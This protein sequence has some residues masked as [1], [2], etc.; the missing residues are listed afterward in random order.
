MVLNSRQGPVTLIYMPDTQV[1]D[2]EMLG[3]DRVEA[4]RLQAEGQYRAREEAL[5]RDLEATEATLAEMQA[6]R[7]EGDLT[8]LDA[9]QQAELQ[10][11]IDQR[12][13]IRT[14]LRQVR[15]DLD[16]EIDALGTRLKLINIVL[17]PALIVVFALF[18]GRRRRRRR[19]AAA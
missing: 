12:V 13:Q 7:T 1:N 10:R 11:F 4:L 8:V 3:F 18:V 14:E 6:N 2:G 9:E 19:E 15:H 17:A 16:R 5:N